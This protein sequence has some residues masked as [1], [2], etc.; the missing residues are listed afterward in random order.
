MTDQ[1]PIQEPS[2]ESNESQEAMESPTGEESTGT[3]ISSPKPKARSRKKAQPTEAEKPAETELSEEPA[4]QVEAEAAQAAPAETVISTRPAPEPEKGAEESAATIGSEPLPET[5]PE[6]RRPLPA[7][8][9]PYAPPPPLP[10]SESDERTYAMLAHLSILLN[11][12][13]GIL[14]PVAALLIYFVYRDRSRYVR[15]H[16][17]Q[18]FVFQLIWWL[19]AGILAAIMWTISG[20]LAVILV[21]CLLMPIAL[22]VTLIP[23]AALVYGVIGAIQTNEHQDFRY[24]LIGDWVRGELTGN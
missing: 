14:G 12:V 3:V 13:T 7:Q 20:L 21:G 9:P 18:S 16:A 5:P 11:L 23:L 15:Y 24:W 10:L 2:E 8:T 19:G 1:D 4:S 22:F 17:M 6:P